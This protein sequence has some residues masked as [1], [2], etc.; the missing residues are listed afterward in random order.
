MLRPDQ[1]VEM[2][3]A[4]EDRNEIR[5]SLE[6]CTLRAAVTA[7]CCAHLDGKKTA[8]LALDIFGNYALDVPVNAEVE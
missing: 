7:A 6:R 1:G 5:G 3:Y 8:E 2:D 4:T